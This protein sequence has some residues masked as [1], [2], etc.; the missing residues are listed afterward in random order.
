MLRSRGSSRSG[1]RP[2]RTSSWSVARAQRPRA[3]ESRVVSAR[4]ADDDGRRQPRRRVQARAVEA[5]APGDAPRELDG[6]DADLVG[7]DGYVMPAHP[8]RCRAV[9]VRE[10]V[11]RRL[12][13]RAGRDRGAPRHRRRGRGDLGLAL[14]ARPR[15]TGFI[16]GTENPT[17]VEAPEVV[18]VPEGDARCWR[19]D[20]A[21]AE[22]GPRCRR[23][24]G[25]SGRPSRSA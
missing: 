11:R 2:T 5:A 8:A 24:G 19:H 4:A 21:A 13:R 7:V 17:L 6:F 10:R 15:P 22:V 12:R 3:R 14:P 9:A 1:R 16:D 25:A 23:V 20:P 18:L